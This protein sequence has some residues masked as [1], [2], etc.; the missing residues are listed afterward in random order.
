MLWVC[1]VFCLCLP[2]YPWHCCFFVSCSSSHFWLLVFLSGYLVLS[3]TA[4][5]LCFC[6][7]LSFSTTSLNRPLFEATVQTLARKRHVSRRVAGGKP[8]TWA[9]ERFWLANVGKRIPKRNQPLC[10]S[11]S[12][13][14]RHYLQ[15]N[16]AQAPSRAAREAAKGSRRGLYMPCAFMSVTQR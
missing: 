10:F 13:I 7:L 14:S 11:F 9:G 8:A 15:N 3:S 2:G 6:Y 12:F 5:F 16:F 4:S 1:A